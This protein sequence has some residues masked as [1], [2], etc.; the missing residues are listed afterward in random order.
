MKSFKAQSK[1]N[2]LVKAVAATAPSANMIASNLSMR[3]IAAELQCSSSPN[4]RSWTPDRI[5]TG[6]SFL[7]RPK[8]KL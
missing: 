8:R 5:G 3:A 4:D 2:Q 6:A 1:P 7:S